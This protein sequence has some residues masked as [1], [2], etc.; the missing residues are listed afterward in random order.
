MLSG[1]DIDSN[2]INKDDEAGGQMFFSSLI[3]F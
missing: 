2:E 3:D 1:I